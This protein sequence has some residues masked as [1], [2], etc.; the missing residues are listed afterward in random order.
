VVGTLPSGAVMVPVK[1]IK[2][3]SVHD[4]RSVIDS[5]AVAMTMLAMYQKHIAILILHFSK[6][7]PR[8]ERITEQDCSYLNAS[9]S[10]LWAKRLKF[11]NEDW[12]WGFQ[13]LWE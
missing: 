10:K 5:C 2:V 9:S 12:R 11:F 13:T 8:L 4:G 3:A 1:G 7:Y 6:T